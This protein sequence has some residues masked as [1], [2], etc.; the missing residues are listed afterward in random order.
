VV[1]STISGVFEVLSSPTPSNISRGVVLLVGLLA[2][3]MV[4]FYKNMDEVRPF[5]K[6]VFV[7]S[8]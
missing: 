5:F 6:Q 3:V 7:L 8:F 4:F 1:L 2:F